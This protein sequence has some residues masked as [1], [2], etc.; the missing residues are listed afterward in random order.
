[1]AFHLRS[2]PPLSDDD[3][4]DDDADDDNKPAQRGGQDEVRRGAKW[5][6]ERKSE[7]GSERL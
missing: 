3:D 1:M 2:I 7:S 5:G 6:S 4:E